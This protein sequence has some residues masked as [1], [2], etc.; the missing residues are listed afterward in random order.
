MILKVKRREK[1][2]QVWENW[3]QQLEI[4][5][6]QQDERN[7]VARRVSA[8]C[9]H[10]T[11]IAS[12]PYIIEKSMSPAWPVVTIMNDSN[13]RIYLDHTF[14]IDPHYMENVTF[15]TQGAYYK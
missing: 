1:T 3:S 6:S 7:Q 12:A 9:W 4:S 10:A 2:R 13:K 5:K 11:P 8:P 15:K 14:Y